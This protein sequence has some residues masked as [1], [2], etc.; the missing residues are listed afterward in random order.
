MR[1]N[2]LEL[3]Q[4]RHAIAVNDISNERQRDR[5]GRDEPP[6]LPEG[7]HYCEREAGRPVAQHTVGAN[8]ADEKAIPTWREM[9]EIHRALFAERAPVP[10]RTFELVLVTGLVAGA[11][12]R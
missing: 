4:P 10:A 11:Q 5:G 12:A 6:T 1:T 7:R 8:R 9:G 3:E 2:T